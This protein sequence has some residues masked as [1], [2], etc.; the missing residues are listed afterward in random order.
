MGI[1]LFFGGSKRHNRHNGNFANFLKLVPEYPVECG[2]R[3]GP[4][5]IW[6]M[7]KCREHERKRV[8]PALIVSLYRKKFQEC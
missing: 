3:D 2:G 6:A 1:S 8:F 7:P 5:A 4:F